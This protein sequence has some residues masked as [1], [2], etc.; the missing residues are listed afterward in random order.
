[1]SSSFLKAASAQYAL[2]PDLPTN[3][4]TVARAVAQAGG[5][6][7]DLLLLPELSHGRYFCQ[8]EDA[9]NFTLAEPLDG[10]TLA[11]LADLAKRHRLVIVATLFEKAATDD[12]YNT[13]VVLDTD[14]SLAGSYRKMHLPQEPGYHEQYY[15]RPGDQGFVPIP[16]SVGKLGVLVCWDQ[17]FP[18]AARL[19]ALAGAE[20]LLYPTAIGW[21]QSDLAT[22][23]AQQTAAWIGIQQAH[24]IAN[25]L[26]VLAA[27]RVGEEI[28]EQQTSGIRFWGNS[29]ICGP[30]GQM[31]A[32]AS[33]E[34]PEVITGL[35]DLSS[36][37]RLREIW[38]FFRDR[39]IDAYGQLLRR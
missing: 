21:D 19:M 12:C 36:T 3:Q 8:T 9:E 2:G 25:H 30:Q 31:I 10:P 15:F 14:G 33:S 16:T 37:A 17:W 22:E 26:P 5:Q 34:R 28:P 27:N 24:A 4:A 1:M 7:A 35:L 23:H 18:E 11:S 38:P 32:R 13:A 29:F 6:H 39:R 20:L